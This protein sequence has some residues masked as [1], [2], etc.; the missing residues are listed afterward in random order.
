[1]S[2]LIVHFMG[3]GMTACQIPGTP[4]K[5]WGPGHR[6]SADWDDVTCEQCLEGKEPIDTFVISPAGDTITC[7][8]CGRVS[9]S[10]GD[11]EH[12]YCGYCKV[13]H[14]DLWP[15]A[16]HWWINTLEPDMAAIVCDCGYRLGVKK[17]SIAAGVHGT[18]C[19]KCKALLDEKIKAVQ[20]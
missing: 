4:G 10:R 18:S 11:I 3:H 14:D 5:D 1:M 17:V 19:P 9:Y 8:R 15:P 13:R 20:L 2:N 6:W 12:H 16:R 7:K